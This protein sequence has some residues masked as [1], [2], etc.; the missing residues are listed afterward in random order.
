MTT[1]S[2]SN[3]RK[4]ATW[5]TI[6]L[7]SDASIVTIMDTLQWIALTKYHLQ[8]HWHDAETTPLVDMMD[9]HLG[10]IATPGTPIVT[11]ET[12]TDSVNLD[13]THVTPDIGVTVIVILT[14]AIPD[15]FTSPHAVALCTTGVHAHTATTV[16]HH[17]ADPH[18]AE[19]SPEMKVDPEHINPTGTATNPHKDHLPVH[20]Q[21]PRSPRI[22]GTNRLQ[23]MIHPQN[24]IAL[25]IRMVIQR[26]I[27]TRRAL[28]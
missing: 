20:N 27:L 14:E 28:F 11:I 23:L 22:E 1:T 21:H 5:H 10:I 6:V 3:V 15:H 25:M 9:Q 2:V 8:A 26:M 18:P 7:I 19:I 17:I 16:T 12:G 13:L 4:L 24:I